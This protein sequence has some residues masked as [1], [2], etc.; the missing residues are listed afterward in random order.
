MAA[1]RPMAVANRA[2][3][4][5]GATTARLV[6]F[7][8]AMAWKACHD[9]PDGA[10][11]ADERR[12]G[13]DDGQR[14]QA[15]L[16]P[17]ALA[18]DDGVEH[19]VDALDQEGGLGSPAVVSRPLARASRHSRSARLQH[20]RQGVA[21]ALAGRRRRPPPARW[22]EPTCV[23]EAVGLAVQRGEAERSCR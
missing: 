22:P 21:G 9:A 4:M 14:A 2:S 10:E 23:L 18:G 1:T 12:G 8:M 13:G 3:A 17:L 11:Q 15:V 6:F 19:P 7:W 20:A 5:A 16:D